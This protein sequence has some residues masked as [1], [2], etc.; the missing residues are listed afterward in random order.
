MTKIMRSIGMQSPAV[1]AA[2][3]RR[4]R[5]PP[6]FSGRFVPRFVTG[7]VILLVWEIVVRAVAPAYVAKPSTVADGDPARDH[8]PRFLRRAGRH[9]GGGGR[10]IGHR[11]GV[12]TVIGL[13]MGR[14]PIVERG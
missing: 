6:R 1:A 9:A 3:R 14:S 11:D 8:R 2:P 12:G 4:P 13:L 7:L 10:G 5:V